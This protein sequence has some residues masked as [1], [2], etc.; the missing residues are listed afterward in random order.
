MD[1]SNVF[2]LENVYVVKAIGV[3][4]GQ[5]MCES[6][7]YYAEYC[8][9]DSMSFTD[10][11]AKR[12]Q[13]YK[14]WD[15]NLMPCQM[16]LI[17]KTAQWETFSDIRIGQHIA[18]TL[19]EKLGVEHTHLEGVHILTSSQPF[20]IDSILYRKGCV[21]EKI[22][23]YSIG[24]LWRNIYLPDV[25]KVPKICF[26]VTSNISEIFRSL[27]DN[28][29]IEKCDVK[30]SFTGNVADVHFRKCDQITVDRLLKTLQKS[31]TQ[32]DSDED[33]TSGEDDR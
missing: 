29:I 9:T 28:C 8:H 20:P 27:M 3:V 16:L 1:A 33:D 25:I 24:W 18:N 13:Y 7:H 5:C 10:L 23:E 26:G 14:T 21:E 22:G 11:E 15:A 4:H 2:V 30:I 31:Q 17:A 12:E 6:C 32:L 19:S